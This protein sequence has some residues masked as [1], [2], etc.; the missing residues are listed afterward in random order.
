MIQSTMPPKGS[1]PGKK[2]KNKKRG[3]TKK[4][5]KALV[6]FPTSD[7][8]EESQSLLFTQPQGT[9]EQGRLAGG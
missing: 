5:K 9:L 4:G 3:P 6:R 7:T 1:S 2:Q 8:D